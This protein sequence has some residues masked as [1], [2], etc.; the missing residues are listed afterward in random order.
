MGRELGIHI[1]DFL[2][3]GTT[4]VRHSDYN[5][6]GRTEFTTEIAN[7][8]YNF[9]EEICYLI[10]DKDDV[11]NPVKYKDIYHVHVKVEDD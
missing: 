5:L 7:L 10:L 4:V 3:D 2:K 9:D 8:F 1:I 11:A 6:C